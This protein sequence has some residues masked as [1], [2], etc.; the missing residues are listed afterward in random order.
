V[1]PQRFSL[2]RRRL[3]AYIAAS[4]LALSASCVHKLAPLVTV[5][6]LPADRADAVAWARRSEPARNT[7]TRFRF[8]YN[9]R[10]R[11]WA[12]RGTARVAPPD[13][14]RF[15]YTGPLGLG[16]GAA[17]VV[18]D[19][20]YWADPPEN[21]RSLVPA[22]RLLWAA[23]G[24][25]RPPDST[26]LVATVQVPS[27]TIWRFVVGLDTVDYIATDGSP[28]T[29]DAEWR[30]AGTI[31]ARSHTELDAR[32]APTAAHVAFPEASAHF[33]LAVVGVDT[34]AVFA[35]SLWQRRR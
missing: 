15:D 5:A 20:T 4:A 22:I 16:S 14:L 17:V 29:L 6:L 21:F 25:V 30:R 7:A 10:Q 28:R 1:T 8:R 23:L 18:G 12:G 26:A 24:V 2:D 34:T 35:P 11:S 9:D 33:D 3:A 27:R 19:S 31:Q 32:G 13:S